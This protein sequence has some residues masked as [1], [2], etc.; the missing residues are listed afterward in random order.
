VIPSVSLELPAVAASVAVARAAV[1]AF[2]A[3]HGAGPDLQAAIALATT[4]AATN[5]AVHAYPAHRSGTIRIDADLED[6]DI[7]IVVT[8]HGNGFNRPDDPSPGLGVGLALMRQES[9]AFEIR[10]HPRG[11]VEVWM[12]FP[13]TNGRAAE[14]PT[15]LRPRRGL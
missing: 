15:R 5:A 4:E 3:S 12:R 1:R 9:S 2:A 13:L 11:G 10:D 6:G 8:D 14:A 7:E